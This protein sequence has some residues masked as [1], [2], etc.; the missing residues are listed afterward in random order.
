MVRHLDIDKNYLTS[1]SYNTSTTIITPSSSV[2][3]S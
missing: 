3:P 1:R 2:D